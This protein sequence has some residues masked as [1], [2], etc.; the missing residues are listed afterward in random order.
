MSDD[1]KPSLLQKVHSRLNFSLAAVVST[2][3][4]LL[5]LALAAIAWMIYATDPTRV[6]WGDYFTIGRAAGLLGLWLATVAITYLTVRVWMNDVSLGHQNVSEGWKAGEKLLARHAVRLTDLPCFVVLGCPTRHQQEKW[7]GAGGVSTPHP[8][9]GQDPA[10]DW[11]LDQDRILIFCRDMGVYGGMLRSTD[12]GQSESNAS[13]RSVFSNQ[14]SLATKEDTQA[15]AKVVEV[16]PQESIVAEGIVGPTDGETDAQADGETEGGE[17][18]VS[19]GDHEQSLHHEQ[20][21]ASNTVSMSDTPS[22]ITKASPKPP[23]SLTSTASATDSRVGTEATA[24]VSAMATLDHASALIRD[25]QKSQEAMIQEARMPEPLSSVSTTDH[26]QALSKFCTRLRAARFPHAPINGILVLVDSQFLSGRSGYGQNASRHSASYT[27]KSY[28]ATASE[29][30]ESGRFIGRAIRSDIEQMQ[31]ELGVA[32]PVTTLV[33]EST[34]PDDYIELCRRLRQ[35]EQEKQVAMGQPFASEQIPT[36][37]AM[38]GLA[39][40]AISQVENRIQRVFQLPRSL[41][42]PQNYR[43]VRMLIRCRSWRT[44][45]RSLMVESSATGHRD[46]AVSVG[47]SSEPGIVSGLYVASPTNSPLATGYVRSV[48]QRMIAQQNHLSWTREERVSWTRY[49]RVLASLV[50]TTVLLSIGMAIQLWLV[51]AG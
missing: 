30:A 17:S 45:L 1:A 32:A 9:T 12:G 50:T 47:A 42:Q 29:A 6:A 11:H 19:S 7:F 20:Y 25:A 16:G 3:V 23:A 33:S 44:G 14:A 31:L 49:R 27:A 36:V 22:T 38:N 51:L 13:Q 48:I 10:L 15:E 8:T 37:E 35:V 18:G 41:T 4:A 46:G 39:D 2:V 43:L 26:Q 40:D 34:Q 5:L 24:V 28:T 21:D